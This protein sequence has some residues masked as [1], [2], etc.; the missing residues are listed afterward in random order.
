MIRRCQE[1]QPWLPLG[2]VGGTQNKERGDASVSCEAPGELAKK[3]AQA[4]KKERKDRKGPTGLT[5]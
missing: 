2:G 1:L 3:I 5:R 4:D